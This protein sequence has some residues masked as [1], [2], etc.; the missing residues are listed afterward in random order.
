M[1]SDPSPAD[2]SKPLSDVQSDVQPDVQS[3]ILPDTSPR[4]NSAFPGS[5]PP[6]DRGVGDSTQGRDRS[7][8]RS[9]SPV[10]DEAKALILKE[11]ELLVRFLDGAFT[12]PFF[13]QP[14]GIDALVGLLPVGGDVVAAVASGYI[15][16][17][18]GMMGVPRRKLWAMAMNIALDTLLGSVPVAGDIFDVYWK[19]NVRNIDIVRSHFGLPPF[20]LGK[21]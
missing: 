20:S 14:I 17:R 10:L 21:Q 8:A 19:A 4:P 15:V 9:Q 13:N 1:V 12:L 16:V 6:K 7:Q 18:A 11:I 2:S 3:D 5:S